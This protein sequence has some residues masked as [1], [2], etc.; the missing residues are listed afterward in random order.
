MS[1]TSR[2]LAGGLGV[3]AALLLAVSLLHWTAAADPVAAAKAQAGGAGAQL[4]S[5]E[6]SDGP[7]GGQAR[8]RLRSAGRSI[9]VVLSRPFWSRSWRSVSP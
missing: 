2:H 5:S 7:L 9:E 1:R 3:L 6:V 4:L 8:V